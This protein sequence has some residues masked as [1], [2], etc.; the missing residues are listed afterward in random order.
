[1]VKKR[2]FIKQ[3]ILLPLKENVVVTENQVKE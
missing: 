1:M 3:I 2:K